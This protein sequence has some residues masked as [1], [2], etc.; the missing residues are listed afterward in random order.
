VQAEVSCGVLEG[1]ARPAV[2]PVGEVE[3]APSR[4][5]PT[6]G[7]VIAR[8]GGLGVTA[9][10]FEAYAARRWGPGWKLNERGRRR[11][12]DELERHRNDAPGYA[13]KIT[14]ALREAP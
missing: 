4:G 3:A 11:A 13:D 10:D 12:W 2:E 14:A 5:E 6:L 9:S 8:A 1:E 7:K